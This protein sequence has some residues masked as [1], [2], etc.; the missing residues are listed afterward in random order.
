MK[1]TNF[2]NSQS[3][4][5]THSQSEMR[6]RMNLREIQDLLHRTLE[7]LI[8]IFPESILI[9]DVK[10]TI[11]SI[12]SNRF[13]VFIMGGMASGKTTLMNALIGHKCFDYMLG[14]Q[15]ICSYVS[16]DTDYFTIRGYDQEGEEIQ[17]LQLSSMEELG[18]FTPYKTVVRV[19]ILGRFRLAE[20]YHPNIAITE[21]PPYNLFPKIYATFLFGKQGL[22][23]YCQDVTHMGNPI[24]IEN[25]FAS[26]N[27]RPFDA[28]IDSH[29]HFI[30]EQIPT[31]FALTKMDVLSLR[32]GDNVNNCIEAF[33][34]EL[35]EANIRS[36]EVIPISVLSF[37]KDDDFTIREAF[38]RK[39]N[40]YPELQLEQYSRLPEWSSNQKTEIFSYEKQWDN[41]DRHSGF[42]N[43]HK[44][45]FTYFTEKI[46]Y[47][48]I[49]SIA[50]LL[51]NTIECLIISNQF[52]M[53]TSIFDILHNLS[54]KLKL[55]CKNLG[56]SDRF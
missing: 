15:C 47:H 14:Q 46:L 10:E 11:S 7:H 5:S 56:I 33:R 53:K 34:G 17:C 45:V 44:F 9:Q 28:H 29:Y 20:K 8:A 6:V 42:P 48:K 4:V 52:N 38:E 32:D 54:Q 19:E 39:C 49:I 55:E 27:L 12:E 51:E 30:D 35:A 24:H 37:E 3:I 1:A 36:A 26:F 43:L 13:L 41:I 18:L 50:S 21:I 16:E 22:A 2:P 25:T 40:K 31:I 23:I